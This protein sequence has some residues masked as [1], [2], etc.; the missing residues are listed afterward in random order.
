MSRLLGKLLRGLPGSARLDHYLQR[1]YTGCEHPEFVL[2]GS[3]HSPLPDLEEVRANSATLFS[4]AVDLGPS[5]QLRSDEQSKLLRELSEY[6]SD[7]DWPEHASADRRFY[8]DNPYFRHADAI[9]LYSM[10]RHFQPRRVIE[11]GSGFSSAL[12]L[13]VADRRLTGQV[14][15]TFVDP[16]PERLKG[17]LRAQDGGRVQI[18][19]SCV[20]SMSASVFAELDRNDILFIDSSHVAKVGSDVNYLLFQVLPWLKPGVLVHVH[21]VM[22]PFEYPREWV[23]EGRAWNEAYLVRAFLQYNDVF[24]I[25]LFNSYLGEHD[26]PFLKQRMP[27]FL[28]NTGGSLWLVKSR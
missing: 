2:R 6:Y 1:R 22:W 5:I 15:F 21:D 8:L 7:F 28:E 25:L 3:F 26:R 27:K 16:H 24:Q 11:I 13:D 12:M 9:A 10:L 4:K 19:E 17:L 20:Q 23:L 18:R 14:R